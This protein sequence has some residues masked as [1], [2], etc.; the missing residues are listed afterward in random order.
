MNNVTTRVAE[1][2]HNDDYPHMVI[3][4]LLTL[5]ELGTVVEV[6]MGDGP[7]VSGRI[8][9]IDSDPPE[10]YWGITFS[11]RDNL[12]N[13]LCAATVGAED[14]YKIIIEADGPSGFRVS[15]YTEE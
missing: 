3:Q 2:I 5:K 15:I 6:H 9:D 4:T 7:T 11:L 8:T 12:G 14:I 10:G 1:D 13:T